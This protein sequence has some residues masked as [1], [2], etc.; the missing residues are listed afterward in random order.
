MYM[1]GRVSPVVLVIIKDFIILKLFIFFNSV[2][3]TDAEKSKL[4]ST[5][6]KKFLHTPTRGNF[7]LF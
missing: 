1:I 4:K 7:F 3:K 5:Y 6:C 2:S